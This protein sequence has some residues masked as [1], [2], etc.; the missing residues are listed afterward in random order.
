MIYKYKGLGC[1]WFT[2]AYLNGYE[3]FVVLRNQLG[4]TWVYVKLFVSFVDYGDEFL[5]LDT[6]VS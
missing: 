3:D 2:V 6:I 4:C 5:P 1:P